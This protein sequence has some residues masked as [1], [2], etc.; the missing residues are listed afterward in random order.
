MKIRIEN[1]KLVTASNGK[2]YYSFWIRIFEGKLAYSDAGWKFFPETGTV[3]TPSE[4]KGKRKDGG[5]YNI[6]L[7]KPTKEFY[8]EVCS[9]VAGYFDLPANATEEPDDV[10]GV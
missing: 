7:G 6:K 3:C 10:Q 1:A 4:F 9:Q 2:E 8:E 5:K